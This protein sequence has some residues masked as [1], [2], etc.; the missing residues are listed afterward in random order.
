MCGKKKTTNDLINCLRDIHGYR[1]YTAIALNMN[2]A[3]CERWGKTVDITTYLAFNS[4]ALFLVAVNADLATNDAAI[5]GLNAS[6][7]GK[8]FF[9]LLLSD[10]N[11]LLLT[12]TTELI[13]LELIF[14]L[15]LRP[16]MLWDVTVRHGE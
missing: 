16:A 7:L 15:E 2:N 9:S 1:Y 3:E 6:S 4:A 13:G 11:L 5:A 10:L 14:G 12:S 8:I